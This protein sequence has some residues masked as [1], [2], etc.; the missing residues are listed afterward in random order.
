MA[1]NF[2]QS[3]KIFAMKWLTGNFDSHE[4][5]GNFIYFEETDKNHNRLE[6]LMD[7]LYFPFGYYIKGVVQG[8]TSDN[9]GTEYSVLYG[10]YQDE[11]QTQTSGFIMIL[12]NQYNP[13]QVIKQY[14][15]GEYFGSIVCLNVGNDGRFYMVELD[16]NGYYR[17]V[18]LN[19]ILAKSP[20]EEDYKVVQRQTYRFNDQTKV[21][22]SPMIMTKHPQEAKYLMVQKLSGGTIWC[23]EFTI[24]VG[25]TN[26]WNYYSCAALPGWDD[27][28]FNDI[29]ASWNTDNQLKFKVVVC[30]SEEGTV[31]CH[32]Y[33]KEFD[34]DTISGSSIEIIDNYR[35]MKN[36]QCVIKNFDYGYFSV[37][38]EMNN[39]PH[40]VV[41]EIKVVDFNNNTALPVENAYVLN[42]IGNGQG[43][44]LLKQDDTIFYYYVNLIS[45]IGII[46]QQ[47]TG[48]VAMGSTM[49]EEPDYSTA[50]LY[51]YNVQ[52]QFNLYTMYIQV[53]NYVYANKMTYY[54][55]P[56]A[57]YTDFT[58]P[59]P[60]YVKLFNEDDELVFAR[61]LYNRSINGN[62]TTST[63]QIPNQFLNDV[64]IEQERLMG[65]TNYALLVQNDTIV[66]NQYEEVYLNFVN[67]WNII[68]QNDPNN[69]IFNLQAATR[70]NS[71]FSQYIDNETAQFEYAKTWI[72]YYRINYD[73]NT[74]T[75]V[76]IRSDIDFPD[77]YNLVTDF[78]Q[79]PYKCTYNLE[80]FAP[81][82]KNV[83]SV[84]M[85]TFEN[86]V[87]LT[88][89]NLNLT[90]GKLYTITQ[91][92]YV[93]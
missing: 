10:N 28:S 65:H 69:P 36:Y 26:E 37:A 87:Y 72:E 33:S 43:I 62:T 38:Y 83:V 88:I 73:D 76:F 15:N 27:S 56:N 53:G 80:V 75:K 60:Y 35:T 81:T 32:Q 9:D 70:L 79:P 16:G 52:K 13:V 61:T 59:T 40:D 12:D 92:V 41:Y 64:S 4:P 7:G 50:N 48:A 42:P 78:S 14:S 21:D 91:D 57:L 1:N 6:H 18:L 51:L 45:Y 54:G 86:M 30:A 84:D 68:N 47:P 89:D 49:L 39:T 74:N 77:N 46:V 20:T 85:I 19:N 93:V 11:Y 44:K 17:F 66:K 8:K 31:Y 5:I 25:S 63:L 67:T 55:E 2:T 34:S 90:P 22:M 71:A 24:N 29:L 82:D 3:Y 58:A 23:T